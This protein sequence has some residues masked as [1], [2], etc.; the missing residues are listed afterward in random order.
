MT[1]HLPR[2]VYEIL[3]ET[4]NFKEKAHRFASAIEDILDNI[5]NKTKEETT[6]KV[7]ETKAKVYN[8]LRNE[9]ATKEFVRAE[10][11]EVKGEMNGIKGE[12]KRLE[13]MIKVL[14]G[15]TVF[16]IT[17]LNP[18]FVEIIKVMFK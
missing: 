8:E 10:I 14:I 4:F 7:E 3:E 12:I 6:D 5:K 11:N 15:L 13:F 2:D 16:I 17:V 1:T 9:L 18:T